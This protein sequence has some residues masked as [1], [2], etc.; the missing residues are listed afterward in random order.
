MPKF[1]YVK[2]TSNTRIF[3]QEYA[4]DAGAKRVE[5]VVYLAAKELK[6]QSWRYHRKFNTWFQRHKE[7]KIATDEYE[8]GAYV[9]FDFQ[10][11]QRRVCQRIKNEFTFEY[12]YL[13]DELAV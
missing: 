4:F 12:S 7:P 9:Y 5:T 6:K 1:A 3:R 13:E 10:N 2:L 11:P 8:Q